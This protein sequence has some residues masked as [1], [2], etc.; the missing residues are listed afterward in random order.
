MT[1]EK[2]EANTGQLTR[3]A[4]GVSAILCGTCATE[5]Y[6]LVRDHP[7]IFGM[8]YASAV[9]KN[10]QYRGILSIHEPDPIY[11]S[12]QRAYLEHSIVL[13]DEAIR[14]LGRD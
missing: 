6:K 7:S 2:C 4:G 8:D 10:A 12:A 1:C 11:R 3:M 5:W 9:M 14:W 13:F